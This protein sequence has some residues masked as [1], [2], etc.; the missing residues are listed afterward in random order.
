MSRGALQVREELGELRRCPPG[1]DFLPPQLACPDAT[2]PI[3]SLY[4]FTS[5]VRRA[6]SPPCVSENA[7]LRGGLLCG[8]WGLQTQRAGWTMAQST[9]PVPDS[10]VCLLRPLFPIE[11]SDEPCD[12]NMELRN[13]RPVIS[14][15]LRNPPIA[16]TRYTLWYATMRLV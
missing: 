6:I 10:H 8:G 1:A 15:K 14:W 11:H 13:F 9:P 5:R 7:G 16:P 3:N 4:E 12:F 2:G